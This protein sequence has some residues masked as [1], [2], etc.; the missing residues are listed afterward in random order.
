MAA[1]FVK[2]ER[3]DGCS[4]RFGDYLCESAVGLQGRAASALER[5]KRNAYW[6]WRRGGW[7]GEREAPR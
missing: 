6:P 4:P 7:G 2:S 1:I 5:C 3:R